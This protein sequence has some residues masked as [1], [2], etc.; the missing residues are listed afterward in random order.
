MEAW[1]GGRIRRRRTTG[2]WRSGWRCPISRWIH[3]PHLRTACVFLRCFPLL[4]PPRTVYVLTARVRCFVLPGLRVHSIPGV[5]RFCAFFTSLTASLPECY[6][7]TP[8]W[9][10]GPPALPHLPRF[11]DKR[12]R[13][14]TH[15]TATY[16]CVGGQARATFAFA[17]HA[18]RTRCALGDNVR[19]GRPRRMPVI[20][21]GIT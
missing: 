5:L 21:D 8:L 7:Y 3:R 13:R 4:Y 1:A 11:T 18:L 17:P 9:R 2:F 10:D 6:L 15:L 20:S 19:D 14:L 12:G 16:A